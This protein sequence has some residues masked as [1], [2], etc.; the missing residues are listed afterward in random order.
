MTEESAPDSR[1]EKILVFAPTGRDALLTERFLNDAGLSTFVCADVEDFRRKFNRVK[2][3]FLADVSHEPR[4]PLNT[5]L[6]WTSLLISGRLS[7]D[8]TAR[9]F[10]IVQRNARNQAEIIEDLLDV[11]RI[12]SGK[13]N[14]QITNVDAAELIQTTLESLR[15]A[16]EAKNI[17]LTQ[18]TGEDV[19]PIKG[20]AVR[21]QQIIWNLL[22]NAVKFTPNGGAV[23]I[24]VRHARETLEIVVSDTGKGI[25]AE[26]L[27]FVF[28]RFLQADGSTTRSHGGLGLGLAIVRHLV[29]LHG[30]TVSASSAGENQGAAFTLRFPVRQTA[31]DESEG[32]YASLGSDDDDSADF[33]NRLAGIKVLVVDDEADNLELVKTLLERCGG[34]VA[35]A[36]SMDAALLELEKSV[37]DVLVSD[38][39]MPLADGYQLIEA[40]RRL[41]PERGGATPAVALTAYARSEDAARALKSGFQK[42]LTKPLEFEKLI[43]TVAGVA[44]SVRPQ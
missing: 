12:L 22:S 44:Q 34:S 13:L 6:G 23:E 40:V 1:D 14:L 31:A 39:G 36:D 29:E 7:D 41:P 32:V 9:A 18:I 19:P 33:D 42:H 21:L 37:P 27:P 3:E 4:T 24:N 20:D 16:A 26:F 25:D 35:A 8:D 30:G 5:I 28:D 11:S 2:D 10:Q 43:S 38:I 17:R 15:P